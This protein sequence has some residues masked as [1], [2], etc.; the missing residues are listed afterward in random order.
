[1]GGTRVLRVDKPSLL[2]DKTWGEIYY[3]IKGEAPDWRKK[4]AFLQCIL[5]RTNEY[6][7]NI[8]KERNISLDKDHPG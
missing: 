2:K 6:S 4:F 1:M 3:Q 7:E 8:K 5:Q